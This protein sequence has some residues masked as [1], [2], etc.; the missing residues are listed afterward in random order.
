MKR[1][2]EPQLVD[3]HESVIVLAESFSQ[4]EAHSFID[5]LNEYFPND[6]Y[7]QVLDLCCG[8]GDFAIFLANRKS[9]NIDA[10]DGSSSVLEI[11]K[12]NILKNKLEDKITTKELYVPFTI[13]KKYDLIY[14]L[15]SLHHF[16][17]PTNFWTTIKNHSKDKT[18][19]FVIDTH[20]PPNEDI[21][22][23]IVSTYEHGES[24]CHQKEAY[25]SLLASFESNEVIEQIKEVG[26][27]LNVETIKTRFEG[28]SFIT[29]WGEI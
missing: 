2:L 11:A 10:V 18:K 23:D 3:E 27:S 6:D 5:S 8:T 4:K 19:I 13:N 17:N 15:S 12:Q 16:H 14:S 29:V 26:L 7:K 9:V 24:E 1:T 21:A 20:R 28:F 25:N 22:R